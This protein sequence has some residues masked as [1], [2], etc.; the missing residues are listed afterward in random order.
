MAEE[1]RKYKDSLFCDLFYSDRDAKANLLSLYNALH[2]TDYTDEAM[3]ELVRLEDVFFKNIKNDIA[4]LVN[5]R[6]IVLG[7]HQSTVNE[8]MPLRCLM[9]VAREYEKLIPVR[10]RYRTMRIEVPRPEFY[11]FYNGSADYP[12][13]TK[14]HL[15]CAYPPS[16]EKPML[17][18]TV[19]IININSN[20]NNPLLTDCRVMREYS[21]F[22]EATR[23]YKGDKNA[24]EEAIRECIANG[25]LTDYLTRKGSEVV[26]MLMEEYDYDTDIAVQRE[27]AAAEG[28]RRGMKIGEKRGIKIGEE[29]GMD[30][31]NQLNSTLIADNRLEDL[32]RS[33]EDSLYQEQLLKE[34]HIGKYSE[35]CDQSDSKQ[36][37][38]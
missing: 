31:I 5:N 36:A 2:G 21:R 17:E 33:T 22:V 29:R 32:E 16:D 14:L 28:E 24:L 25:I 9:Y 27:E 10:D 20:K 19:K 34:Y 15:S 13:E 7:E 26:N 18:L 35:N 12:M 11:T 23:K 37:N 8:N 30:A 3:I 6:R 4:F 1:N 38:S